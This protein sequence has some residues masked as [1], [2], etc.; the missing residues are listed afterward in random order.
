MNGDGEVLNLTESNLAW[1]TRPVV[2]PDGRKLAYLAMARPGFEA[3][4]FQI[5]VRDLKTG[6]IRPLAENWDRSASS[7]AFTNSGDSLLVSAD[8]VGNT[9]LFEL[10]L[11]GEE[12]RKRVALGSVSAFKSGPL[13]IVFALDNLKSPTELFAIDKDKTKARQLTHFSVPQLDGIEMGDFEQFSFTG[14]NDETVYGYVMQPA[15]FEKGKKYP[16]AFLIHGGPQG[17]FG[18]HFHYRWNPQTYAGQGFAAIFIDFHGSTGYGQDFTDSITND[19]GG[20]PLVDLQLGLEA[21]LDKYDF[22]DGESICALGASYGGYMI[23]WI[24]GNWPDRFDCLVNHDGIFDER[25]MYYATEELWFP[26]WDFGGPYYEKAAEYEKHN[27]ANFVDRWQT[28]MLV[29]HGQLDYRVPVTQG[30]ATFTALQRRGIPSQFLYFPDENHWVLKP[31]N[32]VQWHQVVNQ[33]LHEYL[34]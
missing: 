17:S 3:D 30:I 27:P 2:S 28:P 7:I 21:A 20:A 5:M 16:V 8:D 34:D 26:E 23:N 4:R 25:M 13:G 11:A 1:D 29:V 22:L 33:W 9:A 31:H 10:D 15:G 19:Y 12:Q 14:A 32:S 6:K 18:N 24:A